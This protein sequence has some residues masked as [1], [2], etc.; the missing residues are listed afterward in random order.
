MLFSTALD[1]IELRTSLVKLYS[2][3]DKRSPC[4]SSL[5][6]ANSFVGD[7]LMRMEILDVLNNDLIHEIHFESKFLF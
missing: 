2:R 6:K 7:L 3:G 5:L 4:L 1:S